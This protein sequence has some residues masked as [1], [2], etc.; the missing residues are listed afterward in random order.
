MAKN[1]VK[2]EDCKGL[3]L[4]P[5]DNVELY[6][7]DFAF[8]VEKEILRGVDSTDFG[9][10]GDEEYI[11]LQTDLN[12]NGVPQ[13]SK[14]TNLVNGVNYVSSNGKNT[15]F[16]G[17]KVMLSYFVYSEY[18]KRNRL[19]NVQSGTVKMAYENSELA[20]IKN[21]RY[22]AH[23]RWNKGVD[24]FNGEVYDYILFNQSSFLNWDF[25]KQSKF[26]IHGIR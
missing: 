14:Y 23:L 26:I 2:I 4:L 15:I 1:I 25:T 24:L 13:T 8:D 3:T 12:A 11:N 10:L 22:E 7:N 5:L 9:L 21:V 6:F 20:E 18:V 17:I 16:C 19:A